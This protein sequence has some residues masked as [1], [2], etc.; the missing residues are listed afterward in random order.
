MATAASAA[1]NK[2][3]LKGC[4]VSLPWWAEEAR[5]DL[6]GND[7]GRESSLA[8]ICPLVFP[9]LPSYAALQLNMR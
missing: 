1:R 9:P 4:T 3:S 7:G 6:Q 5:Q 2:A 8:L